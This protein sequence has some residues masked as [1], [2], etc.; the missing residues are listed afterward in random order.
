MEMLTGGYY[1]ATIHRVIQPPPDQRNLERLGVFYFT[2]ANDNT[3]LV[4]FT[5]SPKLQQEG[6]KRRIEDESAP[7]MAEWRRGI[8]QSYGFTK[9]QRRD[10]RIEEEVVNGILVKHY[11]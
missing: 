11:N 4:P 8:I 1:K 5:E 3:K 9:L 10:D 7:T 2:M 6:V